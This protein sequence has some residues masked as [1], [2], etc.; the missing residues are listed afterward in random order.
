[1]KVLFLTP[2][3][4]KVQQ[5]LG[6]ATTCQVG[7]PLVG[8]YCS[9]QTHAVLFY[10]FESRSIVYSSTAIHGVNKKQLDKQMWLYKGPQHS[11]RQDFRVFNQVPIH[12]GTYYTLPPCVSSRNK[13]I[14]ETHSLQPFS[15]FSRIWQKFH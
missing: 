5:L 3:S 1:M 7:L 4:T 14:L 2:N 12:Q 15:L 11:L 9:H 8:L 13:R 10:P 6:W